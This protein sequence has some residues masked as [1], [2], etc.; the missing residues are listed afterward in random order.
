M[1]AKNKIKTKIHTDSDFI[2]CPRLNNSLSK[3]VE[4]YPEG[5]DNEKI[6]KVLMMDEDEVE[7][8]FQRAVKKLRDHI[9]LESMDEDDNYDQ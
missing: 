1:T 9:G 7:A 2:Y 3:Y 4:R 6:A 5:V 8:T